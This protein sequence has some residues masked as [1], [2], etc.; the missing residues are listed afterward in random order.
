MFV[1]IW[2]YVVR[3]ESIADFEALYGADGGWAALFREHPG[4]H[5][6]ELLRDEA[7]G[8]YLTLDRWRSEADYEAFLRAAS[9]RY[10]ALDAQGDAL[11]LEERRIGRCTPC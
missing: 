4:Y 2:E 3:A 10:A 7:P 1:V 9:P 8:R 11:T 6:T 5:G